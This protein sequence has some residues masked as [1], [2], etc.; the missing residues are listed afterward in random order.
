MTLPTTHQRA[1]YQWQSQSTCA[2]CKHRPSEQG[3]A[4][5]FRDTGMWCA[6]A[7]AGHM[8]QSLFIS[9]APPSVTWM[10]K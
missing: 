10:T 7:L 5:A 3:K 2:K 9:A 6:I 4:D 1:P 8:R